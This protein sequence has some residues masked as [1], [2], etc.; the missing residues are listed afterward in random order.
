VLAMGTESREAGM[1]AAAVLGA[2]ALLLA[3]G[4]WTT[5]RGAAIMVMPL[6]GLA[7]YQAALF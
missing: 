2:G 6:A 7:A 4:L 3:T 5:S 1:V